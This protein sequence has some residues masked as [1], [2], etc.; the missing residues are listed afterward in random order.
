MRESDLHALI[1]AATAD[2]PKGVM[3]P[4]GD[5]MAQVAV[6]GGSVLVACD[7]V[8]E[9]RHFLPATPLE[10]VARK[11]IARN[12]SD[13]AAMAGRPLA[14]LCAATLPSDMPES[15]VR[16]LTA[17][18][19][20]HAHDLGC[21]LIG[22]DT[23]WHGEP[24]HPLQLSITILALPHATGRVVRRSDA[25]PGD[26]VVVSGA[27]GGS[28][29]ADGMGRHLRF[30]PRVR[31]AREL[32]DRFGDRLG[33][34]IDVS[35]GLGRD[36]DRIAR[37]SGMALLIEGDR[38]PVQ[39]GCSLDQ[40]LRDGEDHELA[41]TIRGDAAGELPSSMAGTPLAVIGRVHA[42]DERQPVGARVFLAG[43]W[44]A[45]GSMGWE[46]GPAQGA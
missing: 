44:H 4:P 17:A 9:G 38:I 19:Q 7:Q 18:L 46:H 6:E 11:A 28:F 8:I 23:S 22:G 36:L 41:F 39:H 1:A 32:V 20:R 12:V 13:V 37:A 45:M 2:L 16:A 26:L 14:C 30:E 21:P 35:D 40:A 43:A 24:G 15:A 27:L 42:V 10:L 31:L 33:A 3:V 29:G 5:D 25:Q 34:M